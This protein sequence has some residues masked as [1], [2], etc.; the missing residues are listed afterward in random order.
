MIDIL[1]IYA[2][3][4]IHMHVYRNTYICTCTRE[5]GNM[6]VC[7]GSWECTL[8][9]T[10]ENITW[11]RAY[12]Y[13]HYEETPNFLSDFHWTRL[14]KEKNSYSSQHL[15]LHLHLQRFFSLLVFF[16]FATRFQRSG[17][18][19]EK[20]SFFFSLNFLW[21]LSHLYMSP[22]NRILH[23]LFNTLC[24]LFCLFVFVS[25]KS[26][27]RSLPRGKIWTWKQA[28]KII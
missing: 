26:E 1:R 12:Y 9:T 20:V 14:S 25:G 8:F 23:W 4:R 10:V 28:S 18:I 2:Q 13:Y 15:H 16:L 22:K 21:S 6:R 5:K 19:R 17:K 3:A 27:F 11:N 7:L 24:M